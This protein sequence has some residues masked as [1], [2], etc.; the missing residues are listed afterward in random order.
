[1]RENKRTQPNVSWL[2]KRGIRFPSQRKR[3]VT[4][5]PLKRLRFGRPTSERPG[6]KPAR[7]PTRKDRGAEREVHSR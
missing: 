3:D 5:S 7:T 4:G 2:T 1:M 6:L